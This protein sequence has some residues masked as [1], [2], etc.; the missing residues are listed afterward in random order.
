MS[1][2]AVKLPEHTKARY[3]LR[4]V[5][6]IFNVAE[7]TFKEWL[8]AGGVPLPDGTRIRM[9]FIPIGRKIEFEVDEVERVYQ[10]LREFS[11]SGAAFD[12]DDV[13]DDT[14]DE[15]PRRVPRS[16]SAAVRKAA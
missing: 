3:S 8:R 2:N 15:R 11:V 16:A 4:K 5:A 13:S 14:R 12:F 1:L 7:S 10:L 9:Y 6:R